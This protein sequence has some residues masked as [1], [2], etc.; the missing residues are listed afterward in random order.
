[1]YRKIYGII[2][3]ML[4][5]S[6]CVSLSICAISPKTGEIRFKGEYTTSGFD[7]P[8]EVRIVTEKLF[9][10][11]WIIKALATNTY[12]TPI[13]VVWTNK[14]VTF[15]VFYLVPGEEKVLMANSPLGRNNLLLFDLIRKFPLPES[16]RHLQFF[17]NFSLENFFIFYFKMVH[18]FLYFRL[19][20]GRWNF[21]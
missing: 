17:L 21:N 14:P 6:S 15:A 11:V 9:D 18:S 8:L 3:C 7:D 4:L 10:R 2:V 19:N 12:E 5:L 20:S 16:I 13:H 1:M